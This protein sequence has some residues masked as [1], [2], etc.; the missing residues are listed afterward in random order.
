MNWKLAVRL[1]PVC[2]NGRCRKRD[3][4]GDSGIVI[5]I[6]YLALG[7]QAWVRTGEA[8]CWDWGRANERCRSSMPRLARGGRVLS[9]R[10]GS[11]R[12][13]FA[14]KPFRVGMG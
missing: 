8:P 5:T 12:P 7:S 11:G 3:L 6:R 1:T 4:C 14:T 2:S 10:R 9:T 13:D